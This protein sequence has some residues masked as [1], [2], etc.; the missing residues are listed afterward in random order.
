MNSRALGRSV[1][2][3]LAGLASL[4]DPQRGKDAPHPFYVNDPKVRADVV[5]FLKGLDTFH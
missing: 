2:L 5:E 3:G 4:L 1:L